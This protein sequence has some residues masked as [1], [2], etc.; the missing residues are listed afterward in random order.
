MRFSY[1]ALVFFVRMVTD[2]CG[3]SSF[4]ASEGTHVK[5]MLNT[6]EM[7]GVLFVFLESCGGA[8]P[9]AARMDSSL[10]IRTG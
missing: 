5:N 8:H 2:A 10:E 7:N 4:G 6:R 1:V 3:A 9:P